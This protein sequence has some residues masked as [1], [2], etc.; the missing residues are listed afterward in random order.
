MGS[1]KFKSNSKNFNYPKKTIRTINKLH[2]LEHCKPFY[3]ENQILTVISLYIYEV[4]THT[5]KLNPQKRQEYHSYNTRR[6]DDLNLPQHRLRKTEKTPII[7][8]IKLYNL[9]PNELKTHQEVNKFCQHLKRYLLE[10]PYYR[11]EEFV[12]ENSFRPG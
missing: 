11:V 7:T 10:R 2:P 1:R 4:I 5:I 6:R 9:L 12:E 8:G 3:K